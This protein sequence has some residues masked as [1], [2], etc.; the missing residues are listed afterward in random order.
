MKKFLIC[1]LIV[2]FFISCGSQEKPVAD[3]SAGN[4][5]I[6][7]IPTYEVLDTVNRI[8]ESGIQ[9]DVLIES[10]STETPDEELLKVAQAIA[11][12]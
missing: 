6:A 4:E 5:V 2:P 3:S 1:L 10:Y 8:D 9:A 12:E 11:K 7:T